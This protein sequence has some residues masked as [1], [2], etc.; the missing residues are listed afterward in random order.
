MTRARWH[1]AATLL[2]AAWAGAAGLAAQTGQVFKARLTPV[3]VDA[4][5][6]STTTGS[7]SATATL[8]GTTLSVTG[9]FSGL[10]G[11]ATIAQVHVGPKGIRGPAVLDLTVTK[12]TSGTVQGELTLT[13]AQV[14]HLRRN[15]LYLQIHSE[16]AP[17]G[18]LW[19]WLLP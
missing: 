8:R 3:P 10:Q 5:T 18:N 9:T 15:R 7:G 2:V 16:A 12:A 4:N 6:Q 19:G 13:A 11:P 1:V 14:D 17:E